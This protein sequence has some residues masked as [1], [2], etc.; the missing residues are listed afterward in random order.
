MI[1]RKDLD[2]ANSDV[3]IIYMQFYPV[4]INENV[5]RV[6]KYRC[7]FIS[8]ILSIQIYSMDFQM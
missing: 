6:W 7:A 5:P 3:N 2:Q 1:I 4:A 8:C